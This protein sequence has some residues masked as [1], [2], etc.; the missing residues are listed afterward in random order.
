MKLNENGEKLRA[1]SERMEALVLSEVGDLDQESQVR[2]PVKIGAPEGLGIGY[3]ASR[4]HEITERFDGLTVELLALPR[5]YSLADREV[6]IAITLDRPAHGN[7]IIRRLTDYRLSFTASRKYLAEH[8]EPQS[9]LD[10]TG[11]RL[12]GYINNLLHTEELAYLDAIVG[13]GPVPLK[14]TSI[15]AQL[16]MIEAGSAIGVLPD[17]LKHHSADLV[18]IL[19]DVAFRRTYWIAV[20]ADQKHVRRTKIAHENL[21]RIAERDLEIFVP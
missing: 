20:H 19:R 7:L 11:H 1:T 16:K 18:T 9:R 2:G 12:C 5:N 17:F 14:S 13:N 10:L 6:D 21:V 3:L 15:V 4:I 8:G